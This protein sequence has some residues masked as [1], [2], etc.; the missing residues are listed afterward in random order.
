MDYSDIKTTADYC[1]YV[2]DT[3]ETIVENAIEQ[4]KSFIEDVENAPPIDVEG[5]EGCIAYHG[6]DHEALDANAII[7]YNFGHSIILQHTDNEN[8][9]A[10]VCGW[11]S[12]Q[13]DSFQGIKQNVA[14]WAFMGDVQAVLSEAITKGYGE[15]L[16]KC[17][18]SQVASMWQAGGAE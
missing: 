9:G 5:I 18:E 1:A 6:L 3:A 14:Y 8:Y 12:M 13:A 17:Q 16:V 2:K 4:L 7:I 10:E 15:H 11:E